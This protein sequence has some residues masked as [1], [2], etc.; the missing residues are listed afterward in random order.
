[1]QNLTKTKNV[2][3]NAFN[4]QTGLLL[5]VYISESGRGA[6]GFLPAPRGGQSD[7]KVLPCADLAL[8]FIPFLRITIFGKIYPFQGFFVEN[9]QN[10]TLF[11]D[12]YF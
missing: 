1:M 3:R 7:K 11:K 8:N 5:V 2:P 10:N 6:L 9:C 12:T 4:M